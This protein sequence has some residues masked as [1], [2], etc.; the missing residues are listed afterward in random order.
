MTQASH[1]LVAIVILTWNNPDDTLDC[2]RTVTALD[3]SALTTIVVDNGST[4]DSVAR[5]R[6]AHPA[7]E[8][9]E[10][11][12][13]LGY[14]GGNNVGI[15][16][17]LDA[18]ADAICILN[19]DVTIEPDFLAP[20]LA[21]L[22][23]RPDVGIVTPLVAQQT[24]DDRCVWAL[25]SAV[26]WRTAAVTRNHAGE[27]VEQWRDRP[28]IEVDIASGAAML[29]RREVLQQA[30]LMDE[31]FFLY[32]EEVDWSLAVRKAGYR[33]LAVPASLVWHEVSATL[34]A[35]SPV[36]DYYMLRNHLRLIGRHWQG[37]RR[38]CLWSRL[39]LRNLL[40]IAAYTVKSHNGQRIPNRNARLFALRDAMLGR[41]GK[42]GVDVERV[43]SPN[44]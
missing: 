34:G 26:N 44:R 13:N 17:A 42:M 29:V 2:L 7:V 33:I 12:E 9:I 20:L 43:C 38:G 3:C 8:L 41:W 19:N 25:G 31:R 30:G 32:F 35:T 28:P 36:I 5:I 6:A 39:V 23:E 18:G 10:T 21:A 14:A 15:R 24:D 40:A 1:Q 37:L 11:G 4:D 22:R 27:P 16:H